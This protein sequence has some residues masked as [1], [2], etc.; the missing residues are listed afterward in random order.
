M[1]HVKATSFESLNMFLPLISLF[2]SQTH[3]GKGYLAQHQLFDQVRTCLHVLMLSFSFVV[4]YVVL[5]ALNV[6]TAHHF[7]K[8]S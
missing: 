1:K 7:V 8:L 3:T 2:C 4:N 6:I 5:N